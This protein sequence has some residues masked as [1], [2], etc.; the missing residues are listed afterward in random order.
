[1]ELKTTNKSTMVVKA[2]KGSTAKKPQVL[3]DKGQ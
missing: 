3:R 2:P 1:M